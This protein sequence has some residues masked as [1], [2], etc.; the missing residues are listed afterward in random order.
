MRLLKTFSVSLVAVLA[1]G[2][3]SVTGAS[4][5]EF[6]ASA[7]V[8]A[9][10]KSHGPQLFKLGVVHL[11]CASFN[12][13]GS[14][15]LLKTKTEVVTGSYTGCSSAMGTVTEPINTEYEFNAE[16]TVAILKPIK[17]T[18]VAA[19]LKCEVTISAQSGLKTITY[20]NIGSEILMFA[21]VAE[22]SSTG[23]GALC[24]YATD[25]TG[26]YTAGVLFKIENG[27][28]IKWV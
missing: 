10:L 20:N 26:I 9:L 28:V 5:H 24:T 22:I 3:I 23:A 14:I 12:A 27:G 8:L 13:H 15:S 16:G 18:I 17:V 21:K 2:A 25:K 6:E 19:G 4:A 7:T 1:L 11:A